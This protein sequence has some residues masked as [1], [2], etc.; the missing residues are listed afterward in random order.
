M[1]LIFSLPCE[2][3]DNLVL[4]L[5]DFSVAVKYKRFW[6]ASQLI[7]F[8]LKLFKS[9]VFKIDCNRIVPLWQK[10]RNCMATY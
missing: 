10:S 4:L 1:Y 5:N 6:A 7:Q 8:D 3:N 2:L 9:F